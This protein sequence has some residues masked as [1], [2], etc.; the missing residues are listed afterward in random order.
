MISMEEMFYATL[1]RWF[2]EWTEEDDA[3]KS[4]GCRAGNEDTRKPKG[5]SDYSTEIGRAADA[6]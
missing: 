3:A 6:A 5:E 2:D 4:N 1:G